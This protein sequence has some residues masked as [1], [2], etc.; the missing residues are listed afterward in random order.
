MNDFKPDELRELAERLYALRSE[1]TELER[2]LLAGQTV[3]EDHRASARN[4]AHYLAL[5]RHDIRKTQAQLAELGLSSLGRTEG[6]VMDTVQAVLKVLDALTGSETRLDSTQ[7]PAVAIG[8][9]TKLLE[10]NTDVL[11]GPPLEERKVRIMVTMPT[12]AA[13]DDSLVRDLLLN[14]MNC[15]R[16]NCAHDN[17]DIWSRMIGNLQTARDETGKNCRILMDLAGPKLRTGTIEPGPAVVKCRPKRDGLGRVIEP[18]HIWLS[19]AERIEIPP[20][21]ADACLPVPVKFLSR[22]RRGDTIAFRDSRDARRK[23]EVVKITRDGCWTT[24]SDTAYFVPGIE[25]R[26]ETKARRGSMRAPE[27][28][29][30][31]GELPRKVQTLLLQQGDTL[32][33][34]R[35]LEPGQ[36]AKYN[37]KN[38][39]VSPAKIGV[40]MPEF[41]DHVKP[42]E[43]VWFDDGKI[44]GVLR[45]VG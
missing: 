14:G 38:R 40:T 16:I 7:E 43:P 33:L 41:F 18:A 45:A 8:E 32:L 17:E 42:G 13:S 27:L 10:R 11:L 6:H 39:I 21:P 5:R 9:G 31:V 25:F 28:R 19:A 26:I 29:G 1:M 12:E 37:K 2:S 30:R 15:M 35:S 20:S 4:L 24:L 3:F 34:R 44:G 22:L 23:M 36:P